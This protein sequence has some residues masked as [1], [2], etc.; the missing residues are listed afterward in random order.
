[1]SDYL[2]LLST[3]ITMRHPELLSFV[4]HIEAGTLTADQR[5]ELIDVISDELIENG[6]RGE[7][8]NAIGGSN[9]TTTDEWAG[10][11]IPHPSSFIPFERYVARHRDLPLHPGRVVARR[12][13]VCIRPPHRMQSALP[14]VRLG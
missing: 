2:R 9:Q 7:S 14:V 10:E 12:P 11:F 1:M 4:E 6:L 8:P 5:D 3:V 13:T